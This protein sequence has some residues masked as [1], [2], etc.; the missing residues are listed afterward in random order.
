M[1]VM[2]KQLAHNI[3]KRLQLYQQKVLWNW[4]IKL[5]V[6]VGQSWGYLLVNN[7]E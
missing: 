7:I 4:Q 6:G 3:Y 1:N 5:M 2:F